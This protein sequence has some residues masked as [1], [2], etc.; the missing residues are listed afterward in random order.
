MSIQVIHTSE[1]MQM[2]VTEM[3]HISKQKSLLKTVAGIF[4]TLHVKIKPFQLYRQTPASQ[5]SEHSFLLLYYCTLY[6][7]E[8]AVCGQSLQYS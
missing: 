4:L 6:V 2:F 5:E 3:P 1:K 8:Y 7:T